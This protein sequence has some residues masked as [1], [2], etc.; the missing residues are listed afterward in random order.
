MKAPGFI[1]IELLVSLLIA[2]FL[3]IGM[4]NSL[5]MVFKTNEAMDSLMDISAGAMRMQQQL[6]R[7]LSGVMISTSLMATKTDAQKAP[8]PGDKLG[9]KTAMAEPKKETAEPAKKNHLFFATQKDKN[10][11]VLTF[12]T[13]NPLASFWSDKAGQAQSR[14][15]RVVYR[16]ELDKDNQPLF[17]LMRQEGMDLDFQYYES[18]AKKQIKALEVASGIKAFALSF[19]VEDKPADKEKTGSD[20]VIPG[21]AKTPSATVTDGVEP[22]KTITYKT[23]D[24]W[25]GEESKDQKADNKMPKIPR[26]VRLKLT[27]MDAKKKR[28]ENF[29]YIFSCPCDGEP[30]AKKELAVPQKLP[31]QA[32][33][34]GGI[35]QRLAQASN[36]PK[37]V[38]GGL[39]GQFTYS[40][41]A[42]A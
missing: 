25:R 42:R 34:P 29:E 6:E 15:V 33:K 40:L 10:T 14:I 19:M 18:G 2:S 27:L 26:F 23:L 32:G 5:A 8:V 12:I 35:R 41:G 21:A 28:E 36:K 16:L 7:D 17:R 20:K 22:K 31:A 37:A 4:M 1:L 3:S 30:F 38:P 9:Q 39:L 13:T 11:E 24:E